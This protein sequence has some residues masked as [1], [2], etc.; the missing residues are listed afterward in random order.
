MKIPEM[1]FGTG[2]EVHPRISRFM[3]KV[4]KNR[5]WSDLQNLPTVETKDLDFTESGPLVL[6]N[7]EP[8]KGGEN[9]FRLYGPSRYFKFSKGVEA[10]RGDIY[11]LF[12]ELVKY[13][14]GVLSLLGQ[15]A[16]IPDRSWDEVRNRRFFSA[17]VEFWDQYLEER[18]LFHRNHGLPDCGPY[19][20]NGVGTTLWNEMVK[21]GAPK[22]DL[23]SIK[24]GDLK[25]NQVIE[26]IR[27]FQLSM[28]IE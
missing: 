8:M 23:N 3:A 14:W 18:H 4:K 19:F 11:L 26:W 7:L 15:D 22:E 27:K 9:H 24:V 16:F 5:A 20:W 6:F 17:L 12:D 10:V 21:A 13:P 2:K 1:L 25:D 28:S